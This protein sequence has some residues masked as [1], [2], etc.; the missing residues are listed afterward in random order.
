[1]ISHKYKCIFIHVNRVAGCSIEKAFGWKLRDHSRPLGIIKE[2]G[3]EK[4]QEYFKFAFVRNPWDRLVSMYFLQ[5][6]EHRTRFDNFRDWIESSCEN[7]W[8]GNS[9]H[10]QF[11][12][13][14]IEGKICMDFVGRFENLQ[15][16]FDYV[17]KKI[18]AKL[19]L[20]NLNKTKH[21]HYSNYYDNSMIKFVNNWHIKDIEKFG[22]EYSCNGTKLCGEND[23]C[24]NFDRSRLLLL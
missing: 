19:Q 12:Q 3:Q 13:I 11:H 21:L 8:D 15:E 24:E 14:S 18:G 16:D 5:R 4:W 1:M 6:K 7:K 23:I 2:I 17:C 9:K 20:P 10:D 22:Y